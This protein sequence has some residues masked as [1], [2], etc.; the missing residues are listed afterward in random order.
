MKL[1]QD[2]LQ[3]LGNIEYTFPH[4][5]EKIHEGYPE[6]YTWVAG[7][8]SYRK[9]H[10]PL[11]D[12]DIEKKLIELK[13]PWGSFSNGF[14]GAL[15]GLAIGDALGTTNE[16]KAPGSFE[17][18]SDLVGGGPFKLNRGEWTDDTS[19]A[20][21]LGQSLIY[22]DGFNAKDQMDKYLAW[23][24][25]GA[26][27]CTGRCFDIGNTVR[28]ALERYEMTKNAFSGSKD[29][30]AAGNGSLMRIAPVILFYFNDIREM[31]LYAGESSK[32][33]HG[34]AEAVS[35]CQYFASLIH[36]AISGVGK[37]DIVSGHLGAFDNVW[38]DF[39]LSD[40][41]LSIKNGSYL[42]KTIEELSPTAYVIDTLEA[43]LWCFS[44]TDN[45]KDGALLAANL[46]GDADTIAAVYGQLAGAYYREPDIPAEWIQALSHQCIFYIQAHEMLMHAGL[47][48]S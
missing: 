48:N 33:T 27:S 2:R 38:R 13:Q 28:E 25:H 37:D 24:R 22:K 9:L 5:S 45:F 42:K 6:D 14:R 10:T 1:N 32:T 21:A 7:Y 40:S 46:G 47:D 20:Y 29:P 43:A 36:S 34:A 39:P 30:M 19:M 35:A 15:I 17:P 12:R 4:V 3:V 26:F 41:V 11:I 44:K 16:F 31:V 23:Y 18:I 8:L